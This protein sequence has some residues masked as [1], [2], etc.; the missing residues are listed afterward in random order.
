[1]LAKKPEAGDVKLPAVRGVGGVLLWKRGTAER[2]DE[3]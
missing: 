3:G 2:A 1:M